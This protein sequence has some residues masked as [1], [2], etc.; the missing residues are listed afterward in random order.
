MA[1]N[2]SFPTGSGSNAFR[3]YLAVY[4]PCSF[5]W[6]IPIAGLPWKVALPT[7]M[8]LNAALFVIAAFLMA[9]LCSSFRSSVSLM[10]L[11]LFVATSTMLVSTGQ[12][13]ALAIS[14]RMIGVWSLLKNRFAWLG[15]VCF[16]LSLA[17][18]PQ[19]GWLILGYFLLAKGAASRRAFFTL[20]AAG[21][22]SIPGLVLAAN[23]PAAANWLHWTSVNIAE[24]SMRGSTNDPSPA[25]FSSDLVTDLQSLFAVFDDSPRVY[26]VEAYAVSGALV[27]VWAYVAFRAKPSAIRDYLGIAAASCLCLLPIYHRHYDIRLMILT[28]PAVASMIE[29][30]G[31]QSVAGMA[32][33]LAVIAL[34][35]PTFIR[36]H[37]GVH[38]RALN[39]FQTLL[40]LRTAPLMVLAVGVFY[41]ASFARILMPKN[42]E[43]ADHRR[44][45]NAV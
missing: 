9:D 8:A 42:G 6:L 19:I 23:V 16:G 31:L 18:K 2:G 21:L 15:Y 7:W 40:L 17:L 39:P 26:N 10:L 13:S 43:T 38:P 25:S 20:I 22:F 41:I 29:E 45:L 5:F 32:A 44:K 12:P 34:S 35:H 1:R 28:F 30:G 11:G 33:P 37:F 3:P 27:L 14:L 24:C 36:D 4:P